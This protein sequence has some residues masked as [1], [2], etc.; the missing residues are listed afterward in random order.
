MNPLPRSFYERDTVTVARDLLGKIFICT[1]TKE[2]FIGRFV[3]TEAYKSDDPACHAYRGLTKRNA[4]LF[5]PVGHTYVYQSYGIHWLMNIVSREAS[6]P[7]GGVLIRGIEQIDTD[8]SRIQR[9]DGPGRTG[10]AL[11]IALEHNSIDV[12][13]SSSSFSVYDAEFVS[14]SLIGATPRIGIS[15]G[16]DKLW[17]FVQI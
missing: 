16:T 10:K 5:G 13:L 15:R 3:E 4:G 14:E 6:L 11:K 1:L 17:R 2:P 7:S 12:T 9:I 8:Y